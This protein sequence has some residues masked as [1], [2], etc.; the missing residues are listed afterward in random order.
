MNWLNKKDGD[1][2]RQP[3]EVMRRSRLSASASGETLHP[4]R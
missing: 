4:G 3:F 2:A 1:T